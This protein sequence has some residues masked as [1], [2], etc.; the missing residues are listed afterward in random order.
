M[1]SKPLISYQLLE[2][3]IIAWAAA[4]PELLA[5]VVV[6]SRAR[7][8]RSADQW[9]DLD[10]IIFTTVV[11]VFTQDGAWLEEFGV[12]WASWLSKTG[13]GYPEWFALYAGGLKFDIAFVPVLPADG[14]SLD[15]LLVG[16]AHQDVLQR[17]IRILF[18]KTGNTTSASEYTAQLPIAGS[19]THEEFRSAINLFWITA[20]RTIKH[21]QRGDLWRAKQA[22]DGE[23]KACLLGMLEWHTYAVYVPQH[24]VWYDG[25]DLSEWADPRALEDLPHT[26]AAYNQSSLHQALFA[27]LDLYQ[28]LA[29][30]TA[31]SLGFL[32]PSPQDKAIFNWIKST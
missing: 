16:F 12:L 31:D 25:R 19:P 9:S 27:T 3:R 5:G 23:L 22:C 10:L 18:D 32:F 28:W 14:S 17:G 29:R 11:E 20:T 6:G 8:E 24:D 4:R 30:E 7:P 13:S 1:S 26:F 21:I 2:E 15:Q